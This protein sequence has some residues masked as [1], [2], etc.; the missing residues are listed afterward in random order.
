MTSELSQRLEKRSRQSRSKELA[1]V[2]GSQLRLTCGQVLQPLCSLSIAAVWHFG[3]QVEAVC[4][5]VVVAESPL[6]HLP[7]LHKWPRPFSTTTRR[8]ASPTHVRQV[9]AAVALRLPLHD[10]L[11]GGRGMEGRGRKALPANMWAH[12]IQL[13]KPCR[14]ALISSGGSQVS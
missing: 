9:L 3:A 11:H 6:A 13:R 5:P 4:R 10:R 12:S 2:L 14:M 8:L 7:Q 1:L